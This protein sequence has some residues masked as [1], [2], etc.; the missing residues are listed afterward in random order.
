MAHG[1]LVILLCFIAILVV[2]AKSVD[3]D[4]MLHSVASDLGLHCLQ[5]SLL[6]D[7]RDKWVKVHENNADTCI[8]VYPWP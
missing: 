4:Q 3:P 7:T 8:D 6:W 2:N 1:P 5:M